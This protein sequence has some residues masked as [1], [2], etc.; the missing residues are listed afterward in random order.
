MLTG[1]PFTGRVLNSS[2]TTLPQRTGLEV[3]DKSGG[4]DFKPWADPPF[5]L[6]EL[7]IA[8]DEG[9]NCFKTTLTQLNSEMGVTTALNEEV[10]TAPGMATGIYGLLVAATIALLVIFGSRYHRCP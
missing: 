6:L 10:S 8:N 4:V 9:K 2:P 1:E 7:S 3:I 5:A